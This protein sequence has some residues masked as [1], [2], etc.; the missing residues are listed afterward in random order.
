MFEKG[1][2]TSSKNNSPNRV[3]ELPS[4]TEGTFQEMLEKD[5]EIKIELI[6]PEALAAAEENYEKDNIKSYATRR[7][8][9]VIL[10]RILAAKFNSI[11][12]AEDQ[13]NILDIFMSIYE[14][15]PDPELKIEVV[16]IL[17]CMFIGAAAF[18]GGIP[19]RY[20]QIGVIAYPVKR[21]FY[22]LFEDCNKFN[23][24]F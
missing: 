23:E 7:P 20:N 10:L 18:N 8:L 17:K 21:I 14:K 6:K 15:I 1:F 11:G 3:Y 5:L 4:L 16:N 22:L 24:H 2:E 13:S 9:F 19:E 12:H